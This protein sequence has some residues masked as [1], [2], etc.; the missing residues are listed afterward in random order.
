MTN[1]E[2]SAP[3]V[4]VPTVEVI[5]PVADAP[6]DGEVADDLTD[7]PP[8]TDPADTSGITEDTPSGE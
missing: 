1:P 5:E 2:Q 8:T 7:N 4:D 6:G 3:V